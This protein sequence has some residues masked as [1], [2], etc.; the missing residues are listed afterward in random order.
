MI[1]ALLFPND[2]SCLTY[3]KSILCTHGIR[4][5]ILIR[6]KWNAMEFL[7]KSNR[8][9]YGIT[10]TISKIKS[11]SVTM[12]S[13]W[14]TSNKIISISIYVNIYHET[15]MLRSVLLHWRHRR[16]HNTISIV[17]KNERIH[18]SSARSN[19]PGV[20]A[21]RVASVKCI[22]FDTCTIHLIPKGAASTGA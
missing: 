5:S 11:Q 8:M 14:T 1:K 21:R 22:T 10:I 3:Q 15:Y 13:Y 2:Q 17:D 12:P 7:S 20:V 4:D 19:F 16:A 9:H 6:Q 18:D